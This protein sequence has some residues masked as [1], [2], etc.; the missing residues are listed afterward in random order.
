MYFGLNVIT[1]VPS[2]RGAQQVRREEGGE[3]ERQKNVVH[4]TQTNV[5]AFPH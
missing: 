4:F 1:N 5:H 2:E 3:R